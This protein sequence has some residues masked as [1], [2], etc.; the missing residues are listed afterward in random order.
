MRCM[1]DIYLNN[2]EWARE[3]YNDLGIPDPGQLSPEWIIWKEN[4]RRSIYQF[5]L[6]GAV[7]CQSHQEPLSESPKHLFQDRVKR[8]EQPDKPLLKSEEMAHLLKY[9]VFNFEDYARHESIYNDLCLLN[10]F[11]PPHPSIID[12]MQQIIASGVQCP[13]VQFQYT[14]YCNIRNQFTLYT[15]TNCFP[16]TN[17]KQP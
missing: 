10:S 6:M 11:F 1:E 14:A 8:L 17:L 13:T 4:F 5:F 16:N 12:L 9:P 7:L 15:H 3:M 2:V